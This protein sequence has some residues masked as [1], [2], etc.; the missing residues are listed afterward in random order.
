[1]RISMRCRSLFYL[2]FI[3]FMSKTFEQN[4]Q[5]ALTMVA[6]IRSHFQEL[7]KLGIG[8]AAVDKLEAEASKAIEMIREV[9]A[10]RAE[11]S[12][13]LRKA[14]VQLCEVKDQ[15]NVLRYLIKSGFPQEEWV[16]F[17]IMDKR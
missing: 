1:M 6:G 12:E 3:M 11:V 16:K 7:S 14:N 13:K 9:D 15:A 5:K 17:G 4:A 10:L 2:K 8:T